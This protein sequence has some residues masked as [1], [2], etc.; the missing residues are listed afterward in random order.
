MSKI[1]FL[2]FDGVLGPG[3][4]CFGYDDTYLGRRAKREIRRVIDTENCHVVI[5]STWRVGGQYEMLADILADSGVISHPDLVI[6]M[7]PIL[8]TGCRGDEIKAWLSENDWVKK[9]AIVD[10]KEYAVRC[11][12]SK[13]VG[14][15]YKDR[16]WQVRRYIDKRLARHFVQPKSYLGT[17][18]EDADELIRILRGRK[19]NWKG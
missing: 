2:D 19:S 15:K 4:F 14:G 16:V 1:L 13:F 18:K 11:T 17:T 3:H 9:Y 10:D 7:T 6:G 8:Q 5:S 12:R